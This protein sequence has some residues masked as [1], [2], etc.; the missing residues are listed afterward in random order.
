MRIFLDGSQI[1]GPFVAPDTTVDKA[2]D[3]TCA[4][5]GPHQILAKAFAC[6]GF[7]PEID[8]TDP[9]YIVEK[10]DSLSASG[11]TTIGG[12]YDEDTHKFS[13]TTNF[14][15]TGSRSIGVELEQ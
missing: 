2:V 9:Q 6:A 14:P 1:S 15:F 13:V 4:T 12:F 7:S 11:Q 3:L 5:P 8:P 10:S